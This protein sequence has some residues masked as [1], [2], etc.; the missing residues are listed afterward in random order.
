MRELD[1]ALMDRTTASQYRQHKIINI[2][3]S[4][5]NSEQVEKQSSQP[6]AQADSLL[7]TPMRDHELENLSTKFSSMKK[8]E[9]K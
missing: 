3:S 4:R 9:S 1:E 7:T 5:S 8:R 2:H 6:S